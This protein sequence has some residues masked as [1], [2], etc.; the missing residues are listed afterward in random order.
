[1]SST[2]VL[3]RSRAKEGEPFLIEKPN[4]EDVSEFAARRKS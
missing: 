4:E 3:R 2:P 1:M